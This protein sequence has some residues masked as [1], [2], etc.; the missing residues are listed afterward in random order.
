VT[1]L[2][3]E[4]LARIRERVLKEH[5]E[6]EGAELSVKPHRPPEQDAVAAKLGVP[7]P[8]SPTQPLYIVTLRKQVQAEDGVTLPLTIRLTV[9]EDGCIAKD[10]QSH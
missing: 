2:S 8:K 3:S 4:V 7:L 10:R 9:D 1:I 6:M 5:P